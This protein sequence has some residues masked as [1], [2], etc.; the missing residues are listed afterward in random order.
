MPPHASIAPDE[1]RDLERTRTAALVG[2]DLEAIAALHAPDYE[3]ITP[4]GAVFDRAAYM[5]LVEAQ[6]FYA[7]WQHG[8]MRVRIAESVAMVR[9]QAL[10]TLGSGRAVTLWHTDI[11]ERR[12][13]RWQA[14]WSQATELPRAQS[15]FAEGG[16]A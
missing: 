14:V 5:A 13:G 10:I 7:S 9:Y 12:A 2:R 15:V 4:L 3:L 16:A 6:P 11:Y 1:L 8:P